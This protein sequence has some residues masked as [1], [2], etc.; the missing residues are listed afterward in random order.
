MSN[1]LPRPPPVKDGHSLTF[2]SKILFA[3][4]IINLV[5]QN[6]TTSIRRYA[7]RDLKNLSP[8]DYTKINSP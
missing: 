1:Y 7:D 3:T 4:A 8:L 5:S 2:P 6:V